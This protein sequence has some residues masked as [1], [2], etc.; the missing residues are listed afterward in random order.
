MFNGNQNS[1]QEY[2]FIKSFCGVLIKQRVNYNFNPQMKLG[3]LYM[4][5]ILTEFKN[6][7]YFY[8][9]ISNNFTITLIAN[10]VHSS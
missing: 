2:T 7:N 8:K 3:N 1:N 4:I 6:F 9:L 10:I 5:T